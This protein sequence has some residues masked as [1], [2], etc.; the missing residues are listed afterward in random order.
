MHHMFPLARVSGAYLSSLQGAMHGRPALAFTWHGGVQCMQSFSRLSHPLPLPSPVTPLIQ[1]PPYKTPC[2]MGKSRF[3]DAHGFWYLHSC[4][5]RHCCRFER[6]WGR[7]ETLPLRP[8]RCWRWSR[9]WM[10]TSSRRRCVQEV[11]ERRC[12][13][14]ASGE[15]SCVQFMNAWLALKIARIMVSHW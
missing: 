9:W 12:S 1:C 6:A 5:L 7:L 3:E 2:M 15:Q 10:T 13:L 4:A 8:R 14:E 11:M